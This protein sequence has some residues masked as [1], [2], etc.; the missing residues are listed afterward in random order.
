MAFAIN[1]VATLL[2]FVSPFLIN[3]IIDF[4]ETKNPDTAYGA[5]LVG[6]LVGS[7]MCSYFMLQHTLFYQ[8]MIGVMSTNSL[9]GMIYQKSLRLSAATNKEFNSGEVINFIQ[10]DAE[11][12]FWLCFQMSSISQIP[13]VLFYCF[14]FLFYTLGMS[15][16][17][18][19]GV[20]VLAFVANIIIGLNLEKENTE[21]MKRKDSRMNHTSEA[22]QNIKTLKFYAWTTIFEAEIQKRR[23]HEFKK[24]Y[25]ICIWFTLILTSLFFF[26]NILSSLVFTTYIGTGHTLSLSTAFQCLVFF[27]L[28]KEPIAMLPLFLSGFI[29]FQVS[30]KRITKFLNLKESCIPQLIEHKS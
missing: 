22:L 10:V 4:I 27:D 1:L 11:Q 16:F 25:V 13:V 17:A 2:S 24:Y 19:I 12:L 21:M 8:V 15:F 20:F 30:M 6:G 28:I 26:P 23:V 7:Q 18:G 3:L 9:I 14:G 5:K 29:Q